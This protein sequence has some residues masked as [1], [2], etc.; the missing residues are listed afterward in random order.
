MRAHLAEQ[1]PL[2]ESNAERMADLDRVFV[3]AM[4]Q[5]HSLRTN[6]RDCVAQLVEMASTVGGSEL[7]T[8]QQL[9]QIESQ[10]LAVD[11]GQRQVREAIQTQAIAALVHIFAGEHER[12]HILENVDLLHLDHQPAACRARDLLIEADE[13]RREQG[14]DVEIDAEALLLTP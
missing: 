1:A 6:R 5:D 8:P 12:A 11:E 7:R 14:G 10:L 4:R 9:Y 2:E 13:L 3:V